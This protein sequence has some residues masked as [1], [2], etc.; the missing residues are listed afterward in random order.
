MD[1]QHQGETDRGEMIC[2]G[3]AGGLGGGA[4]IGASLFFY[5]SVWSIGPAPALLAALLGAVGGAVVGL[6]VGLVSGFFLLG[7]EAH[8]VAHDGCA[9]R[10]AFTTSAAPFLLLLLPAHELAW[11]LLV[12][13]A[14]SG[15]AVRCSPPGW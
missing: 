4:M 15:I 1:E 6:V 3:G 12:A 9:R 2:R 14:V 7:A 10:L 11:V 13:A 5:G 8:V